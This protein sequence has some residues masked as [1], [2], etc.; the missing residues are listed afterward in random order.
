MNKILLYTPFASMDCDESINK[1]ITMYSY[2][3]VNI[4]LS[5]KKSGVSAKISAGTYAYESSYKNSTTQVGCSDTLFVVAH[6]ARDDSDVYS[7]SS[8]GKTINVNDLIKHL[9][10]LNAQRAYVIFFCVCFSGKV[11][12]CA[13]LWK[14]HHLGQTVFGFNGILQNP[15]SI[16]NS[17]KIRSIHAHFVQMF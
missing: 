9:K 7:A 13:S 8:K 5:S 14:Q 1:M 2:E 6:G 4:P 15:L 16:T 10:L 11:G 17:G 12:H 3:K